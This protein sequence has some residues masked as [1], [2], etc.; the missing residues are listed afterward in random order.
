MN[1]ELTQTLAANFI[2]SKGEI[3]QNVESMAAEIISRGEA[4]KVRCEI[5][6]MKEALANLETLLDDAAQE[7]ADK[8]CGGK[9]SGEFM[10]ITVQL[11]ETPMR[12]DY[13]GIECYNKKKKALKD[14]EEMLKH[15]SFDQP[16]KDA[17]S[18]EIVLGVPKIQPK[19]EYTLAIILKK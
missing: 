15:S 16:Y 12:Y 8:I 14:L 2:P 17:E 7:Q 18:G 6:A 19:K 9:S 11:K 1:N 3:K 4:L 10:G 13:S 5:S